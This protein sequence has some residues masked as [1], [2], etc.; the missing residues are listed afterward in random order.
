MNDSQFQHEFVQ[1]VL[2]KLLT[3]ALPPFYRLFMSGIIPSADRG[4]PAWLV[5]FSTWICRQLPRRLQE[6][7]PPGSQVGPLPFAPTLTAA[8]TPVA[9]S[10]LLGKCRPNR[11]IDGRRGGMIVEKCKFL[12]ESNCKGLCLHQCK[13]PAERYFEK[14]LGLPLTV[15][16]NFI[17]QECQW[18]WGET[19]TP[20]QLDADFPKGCIEGCET[21]LQLKKD[22]TSLPTSIS[23]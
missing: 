18:S 6:K 19:P 1:R 22:Q 15:K 3:P 14:E 7:Y 23:C 9:M 20:H 5:S 8:V 16:P 12:Q 10:F 2:G 17:T 13:I 11:R 21:R 4:D